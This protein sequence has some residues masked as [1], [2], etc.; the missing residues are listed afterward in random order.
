MM[1][2]QQSVKAVQQESRYD[3]TTRGAEAPALSVRRRLGDLHPL[4]VEAV[5][6]GLASVAVRVPLVEDLLGFAD[7]SCTSLLPVIAAT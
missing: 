1:M 7:P 3:Q 2:R 5:R 6:T 4:V